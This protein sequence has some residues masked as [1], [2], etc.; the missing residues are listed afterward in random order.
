MEGDGDT[1]LTDRQTDMI[2][3]NDFNDFNTRNLNAKASSAKG[4][5]NLAR[6]LPAAV[7]LGS[8]R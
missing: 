7:N 1:R 8:T 3:K 5:A 4:K 6:M 2:N